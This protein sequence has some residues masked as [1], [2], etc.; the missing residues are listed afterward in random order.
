[1]EIW[2]IG[3]IGLASVV[4][5]NWVSLTIVAPILMVLAYS[6]TVDPLVS[7]GET[8]IQYFDLVLAIALL[9][10]G[11]ALAVDRGHVGL[12]RV[13]VAILV[14]I[15]VMAAATV[16]ASYRFEWDIIA[17]AE[18]IALARLV[19]Q[20][21][22][23]PLVVS[24]VRTLRGVAYCQKLVEYLGYAVAAS[25]YLNVLGLFFDVT[26]GEVQITEAGV[27]YFGPLGDQIGFILL[28]FI[29]QKGLEGR[30]IPALFLTGAL[31]ATGTRGSVIALIVGITFLVW[32]SRRG[33][34][35]LNKRTMLTLVVLVVFS[36]I[37]ILY[38]VGSMQTR[39]AGTAFESGWEQ[40]VLTMSI[41][42]QVF[43]DNILTG[44]G[45]TGFRFLAME[46]GALEEFGVYFSPNYIATT[47]NQYLQAATDGGVVGLFAY[48][49]MMSIILKHLKFAGSQTPSIK[50]S[51]YSASY[52]WLLSLL[53][54]NQ[55]AVWL[56]PGSL[57]SYLLWLVLGLA[58]ATTT[59][60]RR[61]QAV[62]EWGNVR[63]LVSEQT[64]PS[65]VW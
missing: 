15:G 20:M 4:L 11:I 16:L 26:I 5:P 35:S 46:Y 55:T 60:V 3:I 23:L 57:I 36:S 62:R 18:A 33:L 29:Y 48:I 45:Y 1:M 14:F 51:F 41:A 17:R 44:V 31:F 9:K 19:V 64:E 8:D 47:S 59:N 50:S 61:E 25:I 53:I 65:S 54:G 38:D 56:L 27:R 37:L 12:D 40:R 30:W 34:T 52:V 10:T 6:G 32:Q 49:W 2:Q 39:L 28:F 7:F 24:S 21:S 22:V 63:G 42:T 58:I 13:Y 43:V